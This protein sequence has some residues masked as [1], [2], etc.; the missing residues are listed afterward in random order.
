MFETLYFYTYGL[1]F[2]PEIYYF[3]ANFVWLEY[4]FVTEGSTS[5]NMMCRIS[6]DVVRKGNNTG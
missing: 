5:Y 3:A 2:L 1:R 4:T 6:I